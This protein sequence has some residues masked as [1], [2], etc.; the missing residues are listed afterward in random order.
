MTISKKQKEIRSKVDP[1]NRYKVEEALGL[2]KEGATAKFDETVEVA[3]RLG[4][5]AKQGDQQVRG[6]VVLPNGLGS[7][8]RVLAFVKGDKETEAKD[9]GADYTG[10]DELIEKIN[11]GWMEFDAVVATPDM[12]GVVARVGKV[13]GPRGLMPNPKLGTVTFDIAQAVKD[14]K[15]GKAEF[16]TEKAGVVHACIGK[17]SFEADKLRENLIALMET[18]RR[19]K[20][21][22]S[23]GVYFRSVTLSSTMGPG[24]RVD[25]NDMPRSVTG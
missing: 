8:K 5:D 10:T 4:V 15:L 19:L 2:V 14:I 9:A 6:A 16:R 17:T 20:P 24:V 23:K 18:V 3:I 11:G 13:L 21:S 1:Q 12:M 22:S 25:V 7:S